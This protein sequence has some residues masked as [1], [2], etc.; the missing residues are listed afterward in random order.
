MRGRLGSALLLVGLAG[1]AAAPEPAP[2]PRSPPPSAD[3]AR[4]AG[5]GPDRAWSALLAEG[6]E[7]VGR[8]RAELAKSVD[9]LL[10]EL[11]RTYGCSPSGAE[12]T[13]EDLANEAAGEDL[14]RRAFARIATLEPVARLSPPAPPVAGLELS[15]GE[16]ARWIDE[17]YAGRSAA[18]R[19]DQRRSLERLWADLAA[20]VEGR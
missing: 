19:A 20:E 11:L 6:P 7:A 13:T 18:V 5:I 10:T 16:L 2:A 4:R 14:R 12:R 15:R 1:C 8:V 17:A 9:L 3:D